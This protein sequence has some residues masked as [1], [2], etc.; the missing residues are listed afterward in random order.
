[1]NLFLN[2]AARFALIVPALIIG[3][4]AQARIVVESSRVI[5][6]EDAKDVSVRIENA[7]KGSS[8]V[9]S[10]VSEYAARTGPDQSSSPFL[11]LPPVVRLDAGKGQVLRLRRVGGDL[12]QDRESVFTLN[13]ADIPSAAPDA[14]GSSSVLNVIVRNRLKLFYRPK[15][16]SKANPSDAIA[17]LHWSVVSNGAGWALQAKNDSPFHVSTVRAAVKVAGRE[18]EAQDVTMLKPMSIQQF[19]LP[20]VTARPSAGEVQFKYI[21][22][23]GAALERTMPLHTD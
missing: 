22:E 7:G 4:A 8:L 9:Q 5:V 13:V 14:E 16:I 19:A 10:W 15:A 20:G 23:H 6:P 18:V 11:V 21:S 3:H 12:P 2:A 1:M 17:G